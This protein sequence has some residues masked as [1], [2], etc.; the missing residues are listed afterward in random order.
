MIRHHYAWSLHRVG[1]EERVVLG[2][3][4]SFPNVAFLGIGL[5]EKLMADCLLLREL[6]EVAIV[7]VAHRDAVAQ[8]HQER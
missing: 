8:F 6:P 1:L 7:S 4:I 2:L 5:M 3:S